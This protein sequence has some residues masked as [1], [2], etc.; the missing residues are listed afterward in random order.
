MNTSFYTAA[1][2]ASAHQAK[3]DVVANNMA[4]INTI[5][6]KAKN[7]AFADLMYNN[8]MG[9]DGGNQNIKA[10]SGTKLDRTNT[11]FSKGSEV[12]TD[13]ELDFFINGRGFFALRNPQTNEN[14][15]TINGSF[16]MSQKD[17]EFF[18]TSKDGYNVI[19]KDGEPIRLIDGEPIPEPAVY[20]FP[21]NDGLISA[22]ET[23]FEAVAKNGIPFLVDTGVRQGS[24]EGS[25]VDLTKEMTKIIEAQRAY[26]YTLRMVQTTDE[27]QSLVNTLR[28]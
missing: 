16:M 8:M 5:G 4:N 25:N 6:Y 13:S 10:G 19:G 1:V 26:Q 21:K 17:G 9:E 18:L 28:Q 2:G 11:L 12:L 24:L 15:Y 22:G 7:A 14:L 20:E 27:I 3:L 23:N